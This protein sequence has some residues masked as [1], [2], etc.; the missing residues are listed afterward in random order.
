MS[1]I[2]RRRRAAGLPAAQPT[3]LM[4]TSYLRADDLEW[5]PALT[6]HDVRAD[7]RNEARHILAV[8]QIQRQAI[9]GAADEARK[10]FIDAAAIEA[11]RHRLTEAKF[12]LH[13]ARKE[14]QILA[15]DDLDLAAKYAQLDEDYFVFLRLMGME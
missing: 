7:R 1:N 10:A 13:R 8:R 6:R 14:S 15:G 12:Q 4:P 9:E 5:H 2:E 11:G 3:P